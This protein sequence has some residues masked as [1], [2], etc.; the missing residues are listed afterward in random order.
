MTAG[1][2]THAT[3]DVYFFEA[4]PKWPRTLFQFEPPFFQAALFF[5]VVPARLATLAADRASFRETF[6]F[7]TAVF[8][9]IIDTSRKPWRN[10][11]STRIWRDGPP[12][13]SATMC[14]A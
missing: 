4:A 2:T 6:F 9:A 8:L 3:T 5:F 11:I 14:A 7:F 13:N 10:A 1:W 12:C